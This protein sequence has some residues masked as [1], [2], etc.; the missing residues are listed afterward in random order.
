LAAV[1]LT[2]GFIVP[3]GSLLLSAALPAVY[4]VVAPTLASF[5]VDAGGGP[6]AT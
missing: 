4:A 3:F 2:V 6:P 1:G 5:R